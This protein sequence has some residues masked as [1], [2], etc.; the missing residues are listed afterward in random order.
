MQQD[1][2]GGLEL[3]V[4]TVGPSVGLRG[5]EAK[6]PPS[7]GSRGVR[8]D[9]HRNAASIND[10]LVRTALLFSRVALVERVGKRAGLIATVTR[11]SG[12]TVGSVSPPIAVTETIAGEIG[13]NVETTGR[14][15]GINQRRSQFTERRTE[16][17]IGF[18]SLGRHVHMDG[19]TFDR[20][21]NG[22]GTKITR[23]HLEAHVLRAVDTE[24]TLR[25]PDNMTG[26][27]NGTNSAH[28]G[29][30]RTISAHRGVRAR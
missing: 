27:L 18:S 25:D 20:E 1:S 2:V 13:L 26:D 14:E 8:A 21:L 28:P 12:G 30:V 23:V 3:H 15:A 16:E 4:D 19:R 11:R 5:T 10:S 9:G 6:R 24:R 17:F 22:D 7:T 29:R